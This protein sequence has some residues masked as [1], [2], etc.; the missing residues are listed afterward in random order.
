MEDLLTQLMK[1]ASSQKHAGIRKASQT[2]LDLLENPTLI[3]QTPAY[4]LREKCLE[5]LQLALESKTKKLATYAIGGIQQILKDEKFQSSMESDKE[6]HWMP[7]QILNTVFS[8]PSL[9]EDT[10]V[11]I[12]KLL[13]K[14]TF[15]TAWCMNAGVITKVSQ[16]KERNDVLADFMAKDT[17]SYESLFKDVVA[18][19]KFFTAKL[20][21][22][23]SSNQTR[24]SIPL[25]LEGVYT[26]ISNS[27]VSI[28]EYKPFQ[29]VLWKFLCPC[30]ISLLGTPK[31]ERSAVIPKSLEDLGRGSGCSLTAPNLQVSTAKTI[32]SIAVRLVDL[33]GPVT[34]LRP[35]LESLFHR[36]LLYPPPQHRLDALKAVKELLKTPEGLYK[37][38][39]PLFD[40]ES[41]D[42]DLKSGT[43]NPNSDIALLKLIVDALQESCHCNDSAVCITSVTCVDVMLGAL[44][45]VCKG[46]GMTDK[47]CKSITK[48][49]TA[50][51]REFSRSDSLTMSETD[52]REYSYRGSVSE[53]RVEA[54]DSE[55][56][57]TDVE[58]M[59]APNHTEGSTDVFVTDHNNSNPTLLHQ[60]STRPNRK[61]SQSLI[62]DEIQ[63]RYK[64]LGS[65]YEMVERQ[66]ARLFIA[67]LSRTLPHIAR[68]YTVCE[69]D[70]ALQ[71]F[72]SNFCSA[73]YDQQYKSSEENSSSC[74]MA[75]LNAD[76]VYVATITALLLNLK[77]EVDGAYSTADSMSCPLSEK[78]Y[79]DEVLGTGLL[80][81]LSPAWLSEVYR[82][83]TATSILQAAG[84]HSDSDSPL[85][86]ILKDVDGLGSNGRGGQLLSG[87]CNSEEVLDSDQEPPD[88]QLYADMGKKFSKR[89]LSRCWD[90]VLDVLSVL[91]NGKSSCG[92]TSSL[93]LML[94]TEGAKEESL[95]ARE[96][97]CMSLDGL[98]K[99]ARLCCALGLQQRCG[100]VFS[101][102]ASTSCV[103]IDTQRSPS[104]DPKSSTKP[105]MSSK[106]KPVR[107]HASHILSMDVVMTNGLEMGSHSADC[108]RHVFRCS[109]FISKLEHTYFSS[110][111]NQFSLPKV[112]QEQSVGPDN[113]DECD[114]PI[115]TI[116]VVAPVPVAPR[117]N[118]PDLIRQSSKESGWERSLTGG[119]VL[120]AAQASQALCC[121]SQEVDRLFE[122]AAQKLNFC[123]IVN[124]LSELCEAS[125]YQLNKMVKL[126]DD[127][128]SLSDSHQLPM[129]ALHLYRLQEV[130]M[131]IVHS[132]RPLIH[133]MRT[134][135]TVSTHLVEAAGHHDRSVSKM[136]VTCVHDFILAML[137]DRPELAHFHVNELLC[138]TFENMLC[139]ELCDGDVQD[140]IVC[141]ICEL[142]E[143][144]TAD[145]RSGWR[146]L[147]G[148]L[149]AVKIEYTTNEEINEARQRHVA[150]VL[151]VFE[152]YLGTDNILVFANATVDCILCLLKYIRGPGEFEEGSDDD[153][154]SG[155]D[156]GMVSTDNENL[157]IPALR[158]LKRCCEILQTM[159][160]MPACPVFNG[161]FR[162]HTDSSQQTVDPVLPHMDM[163]EFTQHFNTPTQTTIPDG[164]TRPKVVGE[165]TGTSVLSS[166]RSLED[167][168]RT[169]DS[170]SITSNDSGITVVPGEKLV[171][172]GSNQTKLTAV[173]RTDNSVT[174]TTSVSDHAEDTLE[175]MDNQ[176][177]ILHV[178]FLVVDG[179]AGS[180][181]SCPKIYQ[182]D[183]L[184][185]LFSI[186]KSAANIPG[187][188]FALYCVNRLLLPML[189]AW[190]RAGVRKYGYWEAGATNFKQCCGL[191]TDL[192]VDFTQQF[193]DC[194]GKT[195]SLVEV[196][197]KQLLDIMIECIAQPIELISRLGC[198]CIRHMLLSAGESFTEN[199]WQISAS[200]MQRALDVTTFHLRQLMILFE[201]N[202]ENFY[203]DKGQVK[204][205]MRRDSSSAE[206]KRLQ[207]LAHQVF[208][209]D[210]QVSG[211]TALI[212]EVDE[213]KS[214]VFLLYPPG[215]ENSL[216]PD[217]IVARISFRGV[218][219]GLLSHQLLLQTVGSV[220]LN[221]AHHPQANPSKPTDH[222]GEKTMDDATSK[223]GMVPIMSTRNILTL[224]KCL[225]CSN[226]LAGEFDSR[227]GLKFLIQ[228]VARTEVAV[229]LYKQA[230]ASMIFYMN[231]LLQIC[232]CFNDLSR[233]ETRTCL[234]S[235]NVDKLDIGQ[236]LSSHVSDMSGMSSNK[237]LFIQL[238]WGVCNDLC[239]MYVD[240]LSD[241]YLEKADQMAERELFFLIAQPDNITDIVHCKDR[242]KQGHDTEAV[243]QLQGVM[244]TEA[245]AL[246]EEPLNEGFEDVLGLTEETCESQEQ[247]IKGVM[248]KSKREL[249]EEQDSRVYTLA[250]DTL[251]RSLMT[252]Y[253]KR[254]QH[255]AMPAFVKL[256]KQKKGSAPQQKREVIDDVIEKQQK[257]SL[258]KDSEARA[259]SLTELLCTILGLFQQLSDQKFEALLPSIYNCANQLVCHAQDPR[260]KEALGQWTHRIGVILQ[261]M[262]SSP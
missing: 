123:A 164:D 41:Q 106:I 26:V 149:R 58:D 199:M 42:G 153:S 89:V 112:Q 2:A 44:E 232:T 87:M 70:E 138:K 186:L 249:R 256:T 139:L 246:Q 181:S 16:T 227:P 43:K 14:M 245:V 175:S 221:P 76:G 99:A 61:E 212:S 174:K 158:Y 179:L 242:H 156:C 155:S 136:A 20:E 9:P 115:Y 208:L 169:Y 171:N 38:A 125:Q 110:G 23:P 60:R 250:T 177:G 188:T 116:P 234:A 77:L 68:M 119:G 33:M 200:A 107:L 225:W 217:D 144:C 160:K 73:L 95:R 92:I 67:E 146:P 145:I 84:C 30:L 131:K 236:A 141:S 237:V 21:Q 80:L 28:R 162:I 248:G 31:S 178:W 82:Q 64:T 226:K 103:L 13:L 128:D 100:R 55:D 63:R 47:V 45:Q 133:L 111:N 159:W 252:E 228:K 148:A 152:V 69:V 142:V 11:E 94:G 244:A 223:L 5:P 257:T 132:D 1:D 211:D 124:F 52:A 36:M 129:N 109:A 37:L 235:P 105:V 209:L 130:L 224:L 207:H 196:M 35:V 210:S 214:F 24:Q 65:E 49:H 122:D 104:A 91:L 98:Q 176:S 238:L 173:E 29:E 183:T 190:L 71:N 185:M 57:D 127:N 88:N 165:Q 239:Q 220:L 213:D 3:T 117:I 74:Q 53:P 195:G 216:N 140:Q 198:S 83:I 203:G 241:E 40:Q 143:A 59:N 54:S 150:A 231:T 147:F 172:S 170:G 90:G 168:E 167:E 253:K 137:G 154:D 126:L 93:G 233:P 108:W 118:I 134:W 180:V 78:Q 229:N 260:L 96:A 85:L 191:C 121:L 197:L 34:S 97:I 39:C 251:I 7:I 113:H 255:H 12:M 230:G 56:T 163:E 201:V 81:F 86:Q 151:D 240:M 46:V 189:Q 8:T 204:V 27:P 135:S 19:L 262:P 114:M 166:Q 120:N 17:P 222:K 79:V 48:Y 182:S 101:Q 194:K 75:I 258:M 66:N 206:C 254:K 259:Q 50:L 102:L 18:I 192:I 22:A 10:Q 6:E 247:E 161:A 187:P 243:I 261:L 62:K 215:Q 25:L 4:I 32:Y 184:E 193:A 219:V 51:E 202:S 205:A 218:V 15:S 72:S 157:C